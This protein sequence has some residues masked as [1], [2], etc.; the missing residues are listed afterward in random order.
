M[1]TRIVLRLRNAVKAFRETR[2]NA[3]KAFRETREA[4]CEEHP[5]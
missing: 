2:R 1:K 3:V 5:R 4:P